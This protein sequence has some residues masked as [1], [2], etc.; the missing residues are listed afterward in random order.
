MF[1]FLIKK[2]HLCFFQKYKKLFLE[3]RFMIVQNMFIGLLGKH[4]RTLGLLKNQYF[5][6]IFYIFSFISPALDSRARVCMRGG[7]T[8]RPDDLGNNSRWVSEQNTCPVHLVATTAASVGRHS[9]TFGQKST[10][11]SGF[12]AKTIENQ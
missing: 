6:Y 1:K 4:T 5:Q 7:G 9:V 10:E 11:M 2:Y 8:L 3:N 12:R